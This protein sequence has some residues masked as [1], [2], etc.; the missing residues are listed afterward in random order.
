MAPAQSKRKS[1]Q[2]VVPGDRL[3]VI[4]EF[5]LGP[6]TYEQ[7][8][9]IYSLTTGRAL[10]DLLNKQVSVFPKVH[11]SNVPHVGSAVVGQVS[12]VQSKQATLRI[13]QVSDRLLTGFFSGLLHISDVSQ[14][15]VESMYEICK[16]GDIVRARVISEKNRVFHLT[17]NDKDLGVVYAFCSRCGQELAQ[18]RF[19]MRCPDCGNSERR[20]TA[21]DYGKGEV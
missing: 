19:V 18:K 15:Y 11:V 8:G 17:T 14:R 2:F 7:N 9:T 21:Q 10:M 5:T 13:F 12:D 20:K 1:G 16:A 3:G 6:G 4:E